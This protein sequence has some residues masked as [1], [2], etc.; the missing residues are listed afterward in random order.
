MAQKVKNYEL[1][2]GTLLEEA[3]LKVQTI[4][5]SNTDYEFFENNPNWEN[6][7]IEQILKWVKRTES[8][9][10]VFVWGDE[11]ARKNNA[12]PLHWFKI[13]FNYDLSAHENVFEQAYKKLNILFP[14]SQDS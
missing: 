8:H 6:D 13:D 10:T 11:V 14:N 12:I 1:T 7:G 2:D 3:Y 5:I 9:A 4:G